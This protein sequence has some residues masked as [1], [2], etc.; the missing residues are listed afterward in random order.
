MS[1][2]LKQ[3]QPHRPAA[4]GG[5]TLIELLVVI[6]IIALL[7][8]LILPGVQAA[9]ASARRIQCVNNLRQVTLAVMNLASQTGDKLPK[10]DGDVTY[11]RNVSSDTDPGIFGWPVAIL[12]NIDQ[13]ALYR[14]LLETVDNGDAATIQGSAAW[15]RDTVIPG[16]SCPD[17]SSAYRQGGMISY[18]ANLGYLPYTGTT[19]AA[20]T[21]V[22]WGVLNESGAVDSV[23]P[24]IVPGIV[25]WNNGVPASFPK[26]SSNDIALTYATG[27]FFRKPSTS[28]TFS[29]TL[30]YVSQ[31]DGQTQTIMLTENLQAGRWASRN[32]GEIG[33]G[34]G[35]KVTAD[36]PALASATADNGIGTVNTGTTNADSTALTLS[37]NKGQFGAAA[38]ST[39]LFSDTSTATALLVG[40]INDDPSAAEGTAWR[41]SSQHAG[42]SV[43]TAF[44]DGHVSSI[45]QNIDDSVY[46]RL[47]TPNGVKY[48]QLITGGDQIDF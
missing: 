14:K 43:T 29:M 15:L 23:T 8:S 3:T 38:T 10:L 42:G 24:S 44:C 5:F 4:R 46:A 17:D 13:T 16:F 39:F 32:A 12:P 45:S 25:D 34:V 35:F 40:K 19:A 21:G 31:G 11:P 1:L 22:S 6:S 2:S 33:F 27:L 20:P 41:P 26:A 18:V 47:V 48:G 37:G 28:S 36:A 9:R 7:A 30:D